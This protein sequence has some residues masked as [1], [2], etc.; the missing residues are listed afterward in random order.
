[1]TSNRLWEVWVGRI[2]DGYDEDD[3]ISDFYENGLALPTSVRIKH[4]DPNY[5]F[6]G[7]ERECQALDVLIE[8]SENKN[9]LTWTKTGERARIKVD[10]SFLLLS[11]AEG[12]R[13]LISPGFSVMGTRAVW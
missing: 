3:V 2:P 8:A 6:V 11:R 4:G 7:F 13:G 5:G 1:M 10:V 12:Q 9:C